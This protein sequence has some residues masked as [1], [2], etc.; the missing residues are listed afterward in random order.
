[1]RLLLLISVLSILFVAGCAQQGGAMEN[2][3]N[4]TNGAMEAKT[5]KIGVLLPLTGSLANVGAGMR[6]AVILAAEDANAKGG[7]D[8]KKLELVI[9]DT[10]C[11]PAKAV[12]AL[13]K[14]ITQDK[15]VALVGG[16]C[17]GESLAIAP[18]LNQNKIVAISPSASQADLRDKGG[19]YF[20]R[21]VP[22]DAFQ[23]KVAAK[24]AKEDLGAIK[25]A[26]LYQ[27]DEW[28]VGLKDGFLKEFPEEQGFVVNAESFEKGAT[29]VRTQITKLKSSGPDLL[30][31]PCY[32]A[33]CAVA[34]QQISESGYTGKVMGADGGDDAATLRAVGEAADGFTITVASPSTGGSFNQKFK[35]KYGKDAGVYT[36]HIYDALTLLV[37]SAKDSASGPSMKD[38]LYDV[39]GYTGQSGVIS[40]DKYGE[41]TTAVY[42][43]KEFRDGNF[44]LVQ[45]IN[46]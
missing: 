29:D 35:A 11:D 42:D 40:F 7:I 25:V 32:P 45:K 5:V 38:N 30:Y 22:S 28:G 2:E 26:V 3:T 19:D 12:T 37:N 1:M 18:I 8:G 17:S 14:M 39:F 31:M 27:N 33:E 6:D 13:N 4:K 36:A 20:F 34:L 10:S 15:I 16:T 46:V 9:E 21:I 44:T 43:I 23:A 24:Y 41:I